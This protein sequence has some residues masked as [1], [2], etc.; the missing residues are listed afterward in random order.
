M[1][2]CFFVSVS[3][4]GNGTRVADEGP[5]GRVNDSANINPACQRDSVSS[6]ISHKRK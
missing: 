5:A 6:E 1:N 2:K 4:V 3:R